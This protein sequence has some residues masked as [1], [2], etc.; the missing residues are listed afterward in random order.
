MLVPFDSLSDDASAW[1]FTA[2]RSLKPDEIG[3]ISINIETFV[4]GW[5]SHGQSVKAFGAIYY[6][7]I[8]AFFAEVEMDNISGCSKDTLTHFMQEIDGRYNLD[9]FNRMRQAY[10][11]DN[12]TLNLIQMNDIKTKIESGEI[13]EETIFIDSL[14]KTKTQFEQAFEL[15]LK[16]SWLI[17][18]AS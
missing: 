11:Q 10:K 1:I 2:N 16:K 18:V 7:K 8:F 14:V 12:Q 4:N 3:E 6:Q 13:S 9:L 15:P 17:R 5:Q